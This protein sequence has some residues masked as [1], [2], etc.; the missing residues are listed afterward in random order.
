MTEEQQ[1]QTPRPTARPPG[2]LSNHALIVK[3]TADESVAS[4]TDSDARVLAA[5]IGRGDETAF[6]TLYDRYHQRLFR[7]ALVLSRGDESLAQETV[8]LV[9]ITAAKKLRRADSEEHLWN[10]LARVARQHLGKERRRRQR[11]PAATSTET[12]AEDYPANRQPDSVLEE[13]LDSALIG[14]E[15]DEQKIIELFYFDRLTHKEIAEQLN[16]TPKAVSSRLER[17][18]EKLRAVIKNSLSHE[19]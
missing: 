10:W 9:F 11:D 2:I 15:P 5:A 14:M 3:A 12:L 17:I 19:T 13:M 8:Q 16:T 4:G 1:S 18:R 7:L 6:R